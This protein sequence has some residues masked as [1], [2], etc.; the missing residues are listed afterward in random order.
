MTLT[1]NYENYS[2]QDTFEG[3]NVSGTVDKNVNGVV[4]ISINVDEA[5][6]AYYT[7]DAD[8]QVNFNFNFNED[9]SIIDY[10]QGLVEDVLEAL[11]GEQAQ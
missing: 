10:A 5:G 9:K 4:S 6:Y 2:I 8:N 7:K 3:A 11:D 1:K